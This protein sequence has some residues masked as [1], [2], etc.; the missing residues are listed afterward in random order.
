MLAS[1]AG[2]S[3]ALNCTRAPPPPRAPDV[4]P[5]RDAIACCICINARKLAGFNICRSISG[6]DSMLCIAGLASNAACICGLAFSICCSMAGFE[7]ICCISCCTPGF[8]IM[9][10]IIACCGVM[11]GFPPPAS[12]GCAPPAPGIPPDPPIIAAKSGMVPAPAPAAAVLEAGG[13]HGLGMGTLLGAPEVGGAAAGTDA[14]PPP[15]P[16]P[17]NK[18][19]NGLSDAASLAGAAAAFSIGTCKFWYMLRRALKPSGWDWMLFMA[20]SFCRICCCMSAGLDA[21]CMLCRSSAGSFRICAS[22]GFDSS[23][24][25]IWGLA[26][27]RLR[28]T[29][30]LSNICCIMGLFMACCMK[31]V[32]PAGPPAPPAAPGLKPAGVAALAAPVAALADAPEDPGG[33]AFTK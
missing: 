25:L 13:A 4:P 29:S 19:A 5:P 18:L 24:W 28:R 2:M 23:S 10:I 17:P 20:W 6:S 32:M 21:S 27:R 16:P 1:T 3:A 7:S 22:S 33:L 14:A 11:D 26:C 12:P 9:L 8:S 30:G 15:P 31:S